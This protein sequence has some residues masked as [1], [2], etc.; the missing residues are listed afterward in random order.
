VFT[1][2]LSTTKGKRKSKKVG[3]DL[4]RR[5]KLAEKINA[6][7]TLADFDI[8]TKRKSAPPFKAGCGALA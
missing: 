1:G 6:K 5:W 3:R 7:L 4:K 2:F 8:E